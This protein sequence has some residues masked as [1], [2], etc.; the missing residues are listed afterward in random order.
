MLVFWISV[1]LLLYDSIEQN[2]DMAYAAIKVTIYMSNYFFMH[3]AVH[4]TNEYINFA[5]ISANLN[6]LLFRYFIW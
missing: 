5:I 6:E 1:L 3:A 4:T 2:E